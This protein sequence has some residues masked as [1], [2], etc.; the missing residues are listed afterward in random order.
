M[1]S[2]H[3]SFDYLIEQFMKD[4]QWH[5]WQVRWRHG[6]P[7]P[8]SSRGNQSCHQWVQSRE[9]WC[10]APTI[11]QSPGLLGLRHGRTCPVHGDPNH[12]QSCGVL[13]CSMV[14]PEVVK[15]DSKVQI[16]TSCCISGRR[17]LVL[18]LLLDDTGKKATERCLRV[19]LTWWHTTNGF[20]WSRT[21]QC[22]LKKM[23]LWTFTFYTPDL[24][25]RSTDYP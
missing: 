22:G 4:C 16:S 14:E 19:R 5:N 9:G 11:F 17:F 13:F 6:K 1:A 8:L 18:S 20:W 2:I 23:H 15:V 7:M 24:V 25:V 12:E 10:L 21:C 3:C